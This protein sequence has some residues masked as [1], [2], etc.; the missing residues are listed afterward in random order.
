MVFTNMPRM[1][2]PLTPPP[3]GS[4]NAEEVSIAAL[5]AAVKS[6]DVNE[7]DYRQQGI[8]TSAIAV[9]RGVQAR[10][11]PMPSELMAGKEL[12]RVLVELQTFSEGSIEALAAS[13]SAISEQWDVQLKQ[14]VKVPRLPAAEQSEAIP[15]GTQS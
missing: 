10:A 2:Q 14:P 1:V 11:R 13:L 15:E 3:P 6:G 5:L 4:Q 12:H 9:W 8:L 7:L